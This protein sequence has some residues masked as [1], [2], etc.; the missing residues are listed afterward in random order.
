MNTTAEQYEPY[1]ILWN[2]EFV[3][4]LVGVYPLN[5]ER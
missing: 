4:F 3:H 5:V 1:A 2:G